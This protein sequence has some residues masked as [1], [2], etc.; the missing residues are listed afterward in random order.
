[1]VIGARREPAGGEGA[2]HECPRSSWPC[3]EHDVPSRAILSHPPLVRSLRSTWSRSRRPTPPPAAASS[4]RQ[5]SRGTVGATARGR[6]SPRDAYS[7]FV[8]SRGDDSRGGPRNLSGERE[9]DYG[10]GRPAAST[11]AVHAAH[12]RAAERGTHLRDDRSD[13]HRWTNHQSRDPRLHVRR[14]AGADHVADSRLNQTSLCSGAQAAKRERRPSSDS[15]YR[16]GTAR[17][18]PGAA[19]SG[20]P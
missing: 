1:M 7:E 9:R 10:T 14:V 2:D 3:V 16:R 4:Q 5:P 19:S 13:H 18:R 6:Q 11:D 17:T 15:N 8:H 12:V 20:P